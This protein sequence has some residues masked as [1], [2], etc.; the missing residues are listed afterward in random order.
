MG[1]YEV[2]GWERV[3]I[4]RGVFEAFKISS[5][6]TGSSP[7]AYNEQIEIYYYSPKVKAII[8]H[9]HIRLRNSQHD[10]DITSTV[11][12]FNVSN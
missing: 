4:P 5:Y 8:L 7:H 10:R 1:K 11:V 6:A 9:K 2:L 3:Q 12:D